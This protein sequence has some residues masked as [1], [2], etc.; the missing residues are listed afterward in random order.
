MRNLPI[1][2]R[3]TLWYTSIICITFL[4]AALTMYLGIRASVERN[5]DRE[6][7]LRLEGIRVF[8]RQSTAHRTAEQLALDLQEHSGVRLNGDPY[9]LVT[10][11]GTWVYRPAS[12]LPLNIPG[13]VPEPFSKPR[14]FTLDNQGRKFRVLSATVQD[15]SEYYGVQIAANNTPIYEILSHFL[16]LALGATPIILTVAGLGGYWMSKRAMQP[17]YQITQT[18]K[19]ISEQNL[20]GRLEVPVPHDELR[21]LSETLND[22]LERLERAFTRIT[23][24]T[25]NASHELRTPVA[26]I[27]TAADFLLQEERSVPEYQQLLGLILTESEMTTELIANLLTLA[28]ADGQPR[29]FDYKPVDL[30][31]VVSELA[32][33]ASAMAQAKQIT[34][35]V[36]TSEKP[37]I[38]LGDAR[39]IKTMLLVLVDNAVKYTPAGGSISMEVDHIDASGF[40]EV[41]DS[42][43]GVSK[44]DL[45]HIFERFYRA[46][47]ARSRDAGGVGLGLSIAQAIAK[48]HH[49]EISVCSVPGHGSVFR[50]W[51]DLIS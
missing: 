7:A 51:L 3:L 22:M 1:R 49:A 13:D 17:V 39:E 4:G 25:A 21:E 41:R 19:S 45:P 44:E 50:V 10:R 43:I 33:G 20:A 29:T 35:D 40:V 42:G 6:L 24:F 27:R 15:G 30:R 12:M 18:A 38:V 14:V 26:I 5:A 48:A 28:R 37:V 16:W 46:D 23:R 11:N 9:Q 32:R 8:L 31:A 34:F 2:L 36:T 47:K